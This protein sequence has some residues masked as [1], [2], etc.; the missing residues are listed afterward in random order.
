MECMQEKVRNAVT[1]PSSGTFTLRGVDSGLRAALDAEA[2]RRGVSLN[3]LILETLRSSM[4]VAGPDH[5]F[6]DLDHLI[7]VWSQS[8]VEEFGAATA[9][10][11]EID[12]ELWTDSEES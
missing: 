11:E 3:T 8:D 1:V 2:K 9:P 6:H 4:G 10:F 7:G 5:R 12:H